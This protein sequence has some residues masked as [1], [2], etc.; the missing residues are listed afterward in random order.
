[1]N[2]QIELSGGHTRGSTVFDWYHRHDTEKNVKLIL[3]IDQKG[4]KNHCFN[5]F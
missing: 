2:C 1:M 5:I 4:M 3:E